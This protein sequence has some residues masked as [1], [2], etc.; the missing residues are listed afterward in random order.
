MPRAEFPVLMH[1]PGMNF[2]G[3]GTDLYNNNNKID[4]FYSAV[5]WKNHYKGAD[6]VKNV[7]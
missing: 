1:I 5:T 6:I 4:D 7:E 2:A 3:P